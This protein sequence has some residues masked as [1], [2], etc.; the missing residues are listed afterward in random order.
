M[1]NYRKELNEFLGKQFIFEATLEKNGA[2]KFLN[3]SI[4]KINIDSSLRSVIT[5]IYPECY[6]RMP[7]FRIDKTTLLKEIKIN[8]IEIDHIWTPYNLL[9]NSKFKGL[10]KQYIGEIYTYQRSNGT[11]D[12]G[13]K[14]LG[15]PCFEEQ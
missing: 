3:P 15:I 2:M 11:L 8:D 5:K 14:I 13:I 7:V 10:R 4:G 6:Y 1:M 12:Y 9:N